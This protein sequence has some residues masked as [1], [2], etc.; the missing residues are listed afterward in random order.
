MYSCVPLLWYRYR[1]HLSREQV[2]EL[3]APHPD[4]LQLVH[5]WLEHRGIPSSSISVTHGGSSLRL[6]GVPV[7]RANDHLGASYQL[8]RY[9]KTNET[10]VR[11]L[12]YALPTALDGHVQV[13]APTTSFD[14]PHPQEQLQEPHKRSGREVMELAEGSSGEPMTVPSSRDDYEFTSP[15][16]LD[17]IYNTWEYP[18]AASDQNKLGIVSFSWLYPSMVDLDLFMGRYCSTGNGATADFDVI[19]VNVAKKDPIYIGLRPSIEMQYAQGMAYPTRHIFYAIGRGRSLTEDLYL[20]WLRYIID[21]PIIPQ[22]ILI[23]QGSI[24]NLFPREYADFV[25]FLLAHLGMRGVTVVVATGDSGVGPDDC[26][27]G[28]GEL[29]FLP[30]FPAT[31]TCDPFS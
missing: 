15:S 30:F 31:C 22:T 29:R 25:C 11:P 13:V 20:T 7:T 19:Q 14:S 8:F 5:S 17:W 2:A 24:E 3:V 6:S 12:S 16:F 27:D 21:E 10:I 9:I 4:T 23:P 26:D 1:A 28:N 18:L